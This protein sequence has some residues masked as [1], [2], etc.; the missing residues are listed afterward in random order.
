MARGTI[1][2]W[3]AAR[4]AAGRSEEPYDGRTLAE[5]LR[6][7][8][9]AHGPQ[10]GRVLAVASFLVDGT[11][12]DPSATLDD[13]ATIEVLPPFAGGADPPAATASRPAALT[14]AG[15]AA[16]LG[17]VMIL[18]A[19]SEPFVLLLAVALA[20]GVVVAGWYAALAVPGAA[21]GSM[22][23]ALSAL[24][25]DLVVLA[26]VGDRPLASVPPILA[27]SFLAALVHQLARRDGRDRLTASL[28]ATVTVTGLAAL[29]CFLLA[30]GA[31][32]HGTPLVVTATSGAVL[33][34]AAMAL[35]PL[36]RFPVWA[37]AAGGAVAAAGVCLAVAGATELGA[38]V[39][40]AVGVSAA[41]AGATAAALVGR[42]ASPQPMLVGA[43][44][45]VV[46]GPAA[47][48][49]GRLLAG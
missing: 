43:L 14:A 36:V 4:A 31:D 35:A 33:A 38:L 2:Y 26:D 21:G 49:L 7:A 47:Y 15:T 9:D 11:R 28:T 3:A 27:M 34:A 17:L 37:L 30:A 10:L 8:Q 46:A 22:V 13:G 48:V 18:G 25:V 29:G 5:V 23:A 41:A 24:G 16:G 45:L 20:Q 40:V 1:R 44:P 42:S 6:S 39:A 32:R 19:L 12:T